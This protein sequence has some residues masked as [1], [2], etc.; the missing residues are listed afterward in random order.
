MKKQQDGSVGTD[1]S[2]TRDCLPGGPL[3]L[4]A[5]G[6]TTVREALSAQLGAMGYR[7]LTVE[8]GSAAL[9]MLRAER[10]GLLLLDQHMPG[11]SGI[12]LLREMRGNRDSSLLPVIIMTVS[13]DP[14]LAVAALNAGADDHIVMPCAPRALAARMER[15]LERARETSALRQAVTALD[16]RLVRRTLE[17]E[18]L[19]TRIET[20]SAEKA[21]LN[22]R[23]ASRETPA[24]EALS[25]DMPL[26]SIAAI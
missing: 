25:P 10:P 23:L 11:L 3:I 20:L 5:D 16:A 18:E 8:S 19:Q 24:Q 6:S 21:A 15:Q 22:V 7:T 14:G 12:D 17:I 2:V 13:D 26:K 1:A 9:M 4:I